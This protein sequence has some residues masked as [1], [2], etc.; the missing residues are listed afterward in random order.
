MFCDNSGLI[1]WL[2][3]KQLLI[4]PCAFKMCITHSKILHQLLLL[5]G[6]ACWRVFYNVL[7]MTT[8]SALQHV[9][10]KTSKHVHGRK[11]VFGT[12]IL[13]TVVAI[14]MIPAVLSWASLSTSGK[15]KHMQDLHSSRKCCPDIS[16]LVLLS[17]QCADNAHWKLERHNQSTRVFCSVSLQQYQCHC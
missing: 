9:H 12:G 5:R 3:A 17:E 16:V 4:N 14:I 1:S 8:R 13:I 7:T 11:H 15:D 6:F 10:K 2:L